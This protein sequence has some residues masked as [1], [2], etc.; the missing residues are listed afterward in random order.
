[1]KK[2]VFNDKEITYDI[3]KKVRYLDRILKFNILP[4]KNES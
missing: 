1:M 4:M 3:L 2:T